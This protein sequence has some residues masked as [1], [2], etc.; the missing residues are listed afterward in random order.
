MVCKSR[1]HA[2]NANQSGNCDP[3]EKCWYWM[4]KH[5]FLILRA[6]C[7]TMHVSDWFLLANLPSIFF[8][9]TMRYW[10]SFFFIR[11]ERSQCIEALSILRSQAVRYRFSYNLQNA[12]GKN[13]FVIDES[14]RG[15]AKCLFIHMLC[16]FFICPCGI[17]TE[18]SVEIWLKCGPNVFQSALEWAWN[19]CS[20]ISFYVRRNH[21]VDSCAASNCS[22]I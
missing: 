14:K 7:C 2:G 13:H 10:M 1:L 4:R 3:I 5:L 22:C 19:A 12:S 11:A 16:S 17:C 15:W 8:W 6:A 21:S 9:I 20:L 18:F